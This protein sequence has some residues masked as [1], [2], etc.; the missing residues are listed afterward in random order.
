MTEPGSILHTARARQL[1]RAG[2]EMLRPHL[3]Q[4]ELLEGARDAAYIWL[5][6]HDDSRGTR[7]VV[8]LEEGD[9]QI[10]FRT[11]VK[12]TQE[13]QHTYRIRLSIE[14]LPG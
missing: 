7:Y 11:Q 13:D 8:I 14:E 3:M 10:V 4:E 5:A 1:A 6:S 12:G 9:D 2:E